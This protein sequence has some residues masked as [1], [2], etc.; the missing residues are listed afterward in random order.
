MKT[1]KEE[2]NDIAGKA[3]EYGVLEAKGKKKKIFKQEEVINCAPVNQVE[4]RHRTGH[5]KAV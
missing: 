1:E 2:I 4:Q 5:W 3:E